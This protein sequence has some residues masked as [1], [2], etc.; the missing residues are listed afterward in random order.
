[1]H[2]LISELKRRGILAGLATTC[3]LIAS[4]GVA[5]A[6]S[7]GTAVVT[8]EDKEYTI[9]IICRDAAKPE[10]GFSTEP[11]RVTREATGRSSLINLRVRPWKDTPE[12]VISLDR[13]VAW[14]PS[15]PSS[16]GELEMELDMSP[17]SFLRD[18]LPVALT[19][20]LWT[21]GERPPGLTN[22]RFRATCSYRD[23]EAPG[24]QKL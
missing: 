3:V 10:L 18:N 13:Y 12:L 17:A 8:V 6:D 2:G 9:P 23:P 15:K 11:S 4:A 14:V 19:Y 24:F 5:R 16:G 1:M 22:V 20:D 21:E 7:D